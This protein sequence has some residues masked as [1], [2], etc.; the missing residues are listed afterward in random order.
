[1]RQSC[2]LRS[3]RFSSLREFFDSVR[4]WLWFGALV[5]VLMG[6]GDANAQQSPVIRARTE[7]VLVPVTPLDK[8]EQ[9]IRGLGAK[10][11]RLLVDGKPIEITSFDVV[12]GP[13]APT[14]PVTAQPMTV[15]PGK[16]Y[17]NAPAAYS[18]TGNLVI[19]LVDYMNTPQVLRMDLRKHLLEFFAHR[20][21]PGQEIGVY[22]LTMSLVVV[23][24][25]TRDP[26]TL[27]ATAQRLL[28]VKGPP[29]PQE[30]PTPVSA[31]VVA[32]PGTD[33]PMEV[34]ELENARRSYNV[35]QRIRATRT[36]EAF[37]QLA[38]AF[39]GVPGKKTVLWLTADPSPLNPTLMYQLAIRRG[40]SDKYPYQESSRVSAW[41][42]ARTFEALNAAGI[43]VSPVD[44][45]GQVNTGMS[46]W[47]NHHA[48]S[49]T[50]QELAESQPGDLSPYTN[51][52]DFRQGERANATLAMLT[53]AAETGGTVYQGNNDLAD[54]L[55]RA[56]ELGAYYYVLGFDPRTAAKGTEP[57]YHPI[58]V[59]VKGHVSRVLARRGFLARPASLVASEPETQRELAEATASVVDLTALPLT[60]TL[61]EPTRT[62]NERRI[63]FSLQ[64]RGDGLSFEQSE[65]LHRYQ[66]SFV[67]LVRDLHGQ[68]LGS[69]AQKAA[70]EV[71]SQQA[72]YLKK[73]G[74]VLRGEFR[75]PQHDASTGRVVVRDD[76]T[77]RIGTITVELE[78]K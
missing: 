72:E 39:L 36:Q 2:L 78:G 38:G 58:K 4:R 30:A 17:S 47:T 50:L 7:L 44:V 32:T 74:L 13:S 25:F 3:L 40:D 45:R 24:P 33:A 6:A 15:R 41:D 28:N 70:A 48:R 51:T 29:N 18:P 5:S 8:H 12:S 42:L 76:L 55:A 67:T 35:D 23:Q 60:L 19:F 65:K 14:P 37:R 75:V 1:M 52:T 64:I 46:D 31:A 49:D 43:S 20:L 9:V 11:F 63:P 61:A 21:Q 16:T 71:T 62:N 69:G 66:L 34:L 59:E 77:G 26:S 54:L 56:Q 10:D 73:Q 57:G 27:I 53:V 22:A 68:L